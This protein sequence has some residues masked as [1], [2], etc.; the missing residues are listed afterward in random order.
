MKKE[1]SERY[2]Q[3][4]GLL[5]TIVVTLQIDSIHIS[6]NAISFDIY[7]CGAVGTDD[8]LV[9]ISLQQECLEDQ[10]RGRERYA[11]LFMI[12]KEEGMDGIAIVDII[13][14]GIDLLGARR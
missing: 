14:L 9:D 4:M 12:S 1:G 3:N 8:A 7:G 10:R 11:I 13:L 5:V 6:E 2:N